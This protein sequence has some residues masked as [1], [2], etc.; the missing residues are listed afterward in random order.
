LL[1]SIPKIR[2]EILAL[3]LLGRGDGIYGTVRVTYS[4]EGAKRASLA[5]LLEARGVAFSWEKK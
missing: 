5:S 3:D 2:G 1:N 4:D